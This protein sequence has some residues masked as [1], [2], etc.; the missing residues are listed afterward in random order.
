M[1]HLIALFLVTIVVAFSSVQPG[2]CQTETSEAEKGFESDPGEPKLDV[3]LVLDN[4]G[5]MK[6]NDPGFLTREVV[7]NFVDNLGADSRLGMVVFDEE[8][9]LAETLKELSTVESKTAFLDSLN[10]VDYKG[11]FTNSPAGVERAIYELKTNAR[12]EAQRVI[13]FL[14][15]GIV[16][17]GDNDKDIEKEKWLKEDLA[18]ESKLEGI[19]IFGVAFTDKADFRLIQSLALKTQGEYFRA[20]QAEDIQGVFQDIQAVINRPVEVAQIP[21]AVSEAEKPAAEAE[22]PAA[23]PSQA[24]ASQ[25]EE[26]PQA[27]TAAAKQETS[28]PAQEKRGLSPLIIVAGA[29]LLLIILILFFVLKGKSKD[30][31]AEAPAAATAQKDETPMPEAHLI[32]SRRPADGNPVQIDKPNVTIGRDPQ[33]DLHLTEDTV[34][35]FHAT[36]DFKDG[37]FYLEDQRSANGTRL[38]EQ[39]IEANKPIRLKSGDRVKF[40]I[41]EFT[42]MLPGQTPAG[43]TVLG[44]GAPAQP[45]G[46]TVLRSSKPGEEAKDKAGEKKPEDQKPAPQSIEMD[47]D[48]PDQESEPAVDSPGEEPK[49]KLKSRMC[50]N[51]AS[52]IATDVC[53]VC[54]TAFCK[55][56]MTEIEGRDVCSNCANKA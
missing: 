52:M 6:K 2:T 15:D 3:M 14:T 56:C 41:Y 18:Q 10:K 23:P 48:K 47:E 50:P 37:Y 26:E 9:E 45:S 22:P 8:A 55:R 40:D 13:I 31:G 1:K 51:H 42:F 39:A 27:G 44:T 35:S 5:S 7:T 38:N 29:A 24:P 4:S 20:Y 49:T 34:S 33:N 25:A 46:G 21:T 17:T 30:R 36:I 11:K 12:E 28:Q 19:R 43:K 32:D 16:D 54:K 53:S